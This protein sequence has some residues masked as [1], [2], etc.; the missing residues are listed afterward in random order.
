MRARPSIFARSRIRPAL[1]DQVGER[2]ADLGT[3][4]IGHDAIGTE[5]V[6]P[7]LHGQKGRRALT[8]RALRQRAELAFERHVEVDRLFAAFGARDQV[9]Q[10][11]IGL[12]AD[13]HGNGGRARHDLL[14]LGLR[15]AARDRNQ[16]FL[17]R[18]PARLGQATDVGI[19]LLRRLLAD[20]ASV[21][22]DEVG[23]LPLGRRRD[24]A[25]GQHL[26][27][28]LAVIDVHLAAEGLDPV[29]LGHRL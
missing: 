25:L 4:R 22:D 7:F 9:G 26:G 3:A 14:A 2:P 29:G 18:R 24:A 15:D 27:H 20:V 23:L 17:P 10:P 8:T 11:V 12:R 13:H 6:A 28:A 16:R 21:E 5:F 19:D 1:G